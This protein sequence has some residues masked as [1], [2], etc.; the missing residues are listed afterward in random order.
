MSNVIENLKWR[1]ATKKYDTSKKVSNEDIETLIEAM[2]LTPTSYGLQPF[3]VL[4]IESED[5]R[6]R[7]QEDSW[8]QTPIV[9]ASHLFVLASFKT[10]PQDEI[11]E[12]FVNLMETRN[13]TEEQEKNYKAEVS[14]IIKSFG[15]YQGIW[16]AKQTYLVL[17]SLLNAAADLRIDSTPMEGFDRDS[18]DSILGLAQENLTATIVVAIGYRH[19]DDFWHKLKKVRKSTKGILV[20]L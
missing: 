9:E 16:A 5:L 19:D 13:R 7:L 4:N 18:Y 20:N 17:G 8:G 11:D 2:R 10:M 1:N 14:G 12:Y 6:K 3:K 15:D